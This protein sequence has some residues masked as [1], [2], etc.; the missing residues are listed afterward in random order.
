MGSGEREGMRGP[1]PPSGGREVGAVGAGVHTAR[2]RARV[3]RC[4]LGVGG[5]P[6]VLQTAG[7][8]FERNRIFTVS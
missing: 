4:R 5:L 6:F 8:T 3:V 1:G 7:S 2:G